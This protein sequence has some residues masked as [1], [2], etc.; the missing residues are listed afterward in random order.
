[1]AEAKTDQV[2]RRRRD[3]IW[4]TPRKIV[5]SPT[6]AI[7]FVIVLVF[8][9]TAALAPVVAPHEPNHQRPASR[10][11]PPGGTDLEGN[12]FWF[13][14]DNLGRCILTRVMHGARV[15]VVVGVAAVGVA[16]AIGVTLGMVAG[17]LGDPVD[18][19]LGRI[20]D[21]FIAFPG[22][23]L[24]LVLAGVLGPGTTTVIL[25]LGITNWVIYARVIRAEVLSLREREFVEAAQALGQRDH[26][27][28]A[29][30]ILPNVIPSYIVLATLNVADTI[31]A[32]A[33]LSFLGLG[34]QP[35]V[36]SWG[37]MLSAGRN[38]VATS[39]WLATIP[40]L[41]ITIVVLGIILLGDR[42]RDVLDPRLRGRTS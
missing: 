15:S 29:R 39:W 18:A 3:S 42:L 10:L 9:L 5:F 22:L 35:P 25:V 26:F 8:V 20:V 33:A 2:T 23:L 19:I 40:G 16:G 32:E 11:L 36:I 4:T 31:I 21:T 27:I 24:A 38:Y 37:Q 1:M 28:L 13:G 34:I 30:H 12:R 41:A 14:T 17:Y 7:G 6:G